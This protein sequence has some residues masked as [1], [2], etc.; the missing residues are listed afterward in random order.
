MGQWRSA[1]EGLDVRQ[2]D[3]DFWRGRRVLLTGHTGFKGAWMTLLLHSL[4]AKVSGFALPPEHEAGVFNVA[5]P[6][7]KPIRRRTPKV[8]PDHTPPTSDA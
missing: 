7:P 8:A 6:P 4:G 2:P 1:V 3:P 5:G